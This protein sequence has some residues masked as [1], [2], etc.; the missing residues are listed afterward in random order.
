[1]KIKKLLRSLESRGF[2]ITTNDGTRKKIFPP[3][4]DLPFYSF[5]GD[6]HDEHAFF[7]LKQFA[8]KNWG[9]DLNN[10]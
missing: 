3:R 6:F 5:H 9:I 4:Q 8:K 7:P 10:L 2:R 1:M